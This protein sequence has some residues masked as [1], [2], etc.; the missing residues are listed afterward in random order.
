[1]GHLSLEPRPDAVIDEKREKIIELLTYI[2]ERLSEL[3]EEKSELQEYQKSDK[4]R[5]CLEYALYQRELEEVTR[6]L[7]QIE[8]ER[9]NDVHNSNQ[10]RRDFNQREVVVQVRR[11]PLN[12]PEDES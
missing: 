3:E 12:F 7:D 11:P 4:D 1:M 9:R 8:E 10:T 5:R 6:S 2:E